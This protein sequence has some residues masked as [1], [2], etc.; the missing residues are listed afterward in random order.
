MM[1]NQHSVFFLNLHGKKVWCVQG[2]QGAVTSGV[3]FAA[4]LA[5][6]PRIFDLS[7]L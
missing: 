5:E 4:L 1:V 2:Q 3:L 6:K 7:T